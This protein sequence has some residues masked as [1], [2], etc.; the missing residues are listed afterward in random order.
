MITLSGTS[1]AALDAG[2]SVLV[3]AHAHFHPGFER[4]T[5]L[6]AAAR[7]LGSAA[8]H[9][10]R[11]TGILM[12]AEPHLS[13]DP[14]APWREGDG[15]NS[16]TIEPTR[17]SES[18]LARRGDGLTIALVA[19]RHL[20]SM[21]G[22]DVLALATDAEFL[23]RRPLHELIAQ[24]HM[25]RGV[26]V[27]PWGFGK[28]WGGR[29]RVLMRLVAGEHALPVL[30]ADSGCRPAHSAEHVAFRS[31]RRSGF[32]VLGGSDPLPIP[33]H[34]TRVGSYGF[35]M[36]GR[37]QP[38]NPAAQVRDYLRGLRKSPETFGRRA[39]ALGFVVSQ[40]SLRLARH[41]RMLARNHEAGR[42]A[43]GH[44]DAAAGP[45][46]GGIVD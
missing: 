2:G 43:R 16:W 8:S 9:P 36:P 41:P 28:W 31:A 7:N 33:S 46:R 40:I 5:F 22:L 44:D 21:E 37:L 3:D 38:A 15:I 19:G 6:D 27:I 23:I 34:A 25:A 29:R 10:S 20:V 39:S 45:V 1:E 17:E 24:I 13:G 4:R 30:L 14:L 32:P 11:V 26:P 12:M 42:G 35:V 18:L